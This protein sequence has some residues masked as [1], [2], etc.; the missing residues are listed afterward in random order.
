MT[1]ILLKK[2]FLH[3]LRA[4]ATLL[5]LFAVPVLFLLLYGYAISQDVNSVKVACV[6]EGNVNDAHSVTQRL[7]HNHIFEYKGVLGSVAEGERMMHNNQLDGI[8]VI[9]RH[10]KGLCIDGSNPIV[11]SATTVYLKA[12]LGMS[13]NK[14]DEL[15]NTRMLYN[16]Q[17]LSA[18]N[19]IP[20]IIG[21]V[22]IAIFGLLT[23]SAIVQEKVNGTL[24]V[25]TISPMRLWQL[26]LAKVLAY[27]LLTAAVTLVLMILSRMLFDVPINGSIP[28]LIMVLLIYILVTLCIGFLISAVADN[29]VNAFGAHNIFAQTLSLLLSGAMFPIENLPDMVQ[30]VCKLIPTTWCVDA[31]RKLMIQGQGMADVADHLLVLSAMCVVLIILSVYKL[32]KTI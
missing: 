14:R 18:Y 22:I 15:F 29:E 7:E 13:V 25:I 11:A 4:P 19:F 9:R 20:G 3:V 5:F 28:A 24:D 1:L 16:P 2:E 21:L 31:L 23:S 27:F 32:K 6:I 26:F 8:V 17:L 10:D 30:P 12:A